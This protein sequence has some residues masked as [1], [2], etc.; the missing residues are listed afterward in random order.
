MAN[1]R[2][3]NAIRSTIRSLKRQGYKNI[4]A[5]IPGYD[6]PDPIGKE[7]R[8]PDIVATKRGSRKIIEVEP[9]DQVEKHKDQHATFRRHAAQKRGTTF[10][11]EEF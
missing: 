5:D 7:G 1:T 2:H 10:E 11:I 9:K 4:W 3:D 8:V 6:S